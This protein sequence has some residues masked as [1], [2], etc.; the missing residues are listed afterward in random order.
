[1]L[2]RAWSNWQF[3]EPCSQLRD[4]LQHLPPDL[5]FGQEVKG[6]FVLLN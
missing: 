4:L 1:M 5:P 2:V 3:F 6:Y